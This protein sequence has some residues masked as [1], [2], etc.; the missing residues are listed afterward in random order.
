MA[1]ENSVIES[2]IDEQEAAAEATRLAMYATEPVKA[3]TQD[4]GEGDLLDKDGNKIV[5]PDEGSETPEKVAGSAEGEDGSGAGEPPELD[6]KKEAS[7][8]KKY[9]TLKG[10]YDKEVPKAAADL[11]GIRAE[12]RQW[13]EYATTLEGK[14]KTAEETVKAAPVVEAKKVDEKTDLDVSDPELQTLLAD[15]PGMGKILSSM[16]G[17]RTKDKEKIAAL[18]ALVASSGDKMKTI[19]S[20]VAGSRTS[21]FESD[22]VALVGSDWRATDT[23]PGFMEFLG[24]EVPYIGKTRLQ[25]LKAA[26]A[27]LDAQT[28]SKFFNDYRNSLGDEANDA[29]AEETEE[30]KG[31]TGKTGGD[32]LRKFVAPPRSGGSPPASRQAQDAVYTRIQYQKFIDDTIKGRYN[33]KEWG[34]R[35][36][37]EMDIVFDKAIAAGTLQ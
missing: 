35:P 30:D 2:R 14:V 12:L 13:Q 19:E 29:G 17:E 37:A 1:T 34:G 5:K 32:K 11:K 16:E 27:N 8:E 36:E 18:E 26:S 28:V 7:F 9:I 33:P 23:D 6:P 24:E 21:R 22:M 20:D 25:L 31:A 4:D 3:D 10:K 15:Y